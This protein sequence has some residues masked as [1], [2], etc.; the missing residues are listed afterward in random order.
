[1]ASVKKEASKK[2]S[3]SIPV[4]VLEEI[5]NLCAVKFLNRSQWFVQA[6]MEKLEKDRFE[7]SKA[8]LKRLEE[9]EQK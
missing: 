9:L 5:D 8:L 7:K 3:I 6:G 4:T 2:V 1:M